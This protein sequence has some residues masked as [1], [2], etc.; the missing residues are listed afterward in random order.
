M[1]RATS[2]IRAGPLYLDSGQSSLS[3]QV[4]V[5]VQVQLAWVVTILEKEMSA[6]GCTLHNHI[7]HASYHDLK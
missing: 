6:A 5:H 2:Q 1:P 7:S 3:V 4:Q